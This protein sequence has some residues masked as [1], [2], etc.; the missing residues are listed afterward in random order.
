MIEM[1]M[2]YDIPDVYYGLFNNQ[3]QSGRSISSR[4]ASSCPSAAAQ[5]RWRYETLEDYQPLVPPLNSRLSLH[6]PCHSLLC[7]GPPGRLPRSL[8]WI[9]ALSILYRSLNIRPWLIF[10]VDRLTISRDLSAP[11]LHYAR[12][13]TERRDLFRQ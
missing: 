12:S 9:C 2:M 10:A 4:L 13:I 11:A 6:S 7:P 5:E 1:R 8:L 3:V